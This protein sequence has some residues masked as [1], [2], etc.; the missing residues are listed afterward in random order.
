MEKMTRFKICFIGM[1]R[2]YVMVW[3]R[4]QKSAEKIGMH[5]AR[6]T[7]RDMREHPAIAYVVE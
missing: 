7:G 2:Y 4:D 1:P 3:S 6:L 5:S